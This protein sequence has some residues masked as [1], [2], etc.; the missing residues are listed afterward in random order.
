MV[1]QNDKFDGKHIP[2]Y[3]SICWPQTDQI[4]LGELLFTEI[5]YGDRCMGLTFSIF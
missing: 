2:V 3:D 5:R 4:F 1:A